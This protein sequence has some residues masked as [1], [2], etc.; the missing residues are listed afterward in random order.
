MKTIKGATTFLRVIIFLFAIAVLGLCVYWLP[1]LAIKEPKINPGV[2]SLYPLL[3]YVYGVCI[4][5]SF[6][7]YHAYKLLSYIDLNNAFS[8][9]TFESLDIIKKCGFAIILFLGLGIVTLKIIA[10]SSGDDPAGPIALSLLAII[11]TSIIIAFIDVLQ[12][13]LKKYLDS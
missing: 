4:A 7:L 9:K 11:T 10:A 3:L 6:A 1:G 13:P 12:K 5:F 2:Y 8:E